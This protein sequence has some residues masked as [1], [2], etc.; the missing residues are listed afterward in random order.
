MTAEIGVLIYYE[1][2][3]ESNTYRSGEHAIAGWVMRRAAPEFVA[4]ASVMI[5]SDRSTSGCSHMEI[6]ARLPDRRPAARTEV[7]AVL[8]GQY[9]RSHRQSVHGR[10]PD[11]H[12][13]GLYRGIAVYAAT[14]DI[15]L[16]QDDPGLCTADRMRML[17]IRM[18]YIGTWRMRE[19]DVAA[20]LLEVLVAI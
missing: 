5:L 18:M 19:L 4:M 2:V 3:K 8:H 16:G 11:G 9:S 10:S 12:G 1:G 15:S 13:I 14:D 20:K 6:A 17:G 7:G